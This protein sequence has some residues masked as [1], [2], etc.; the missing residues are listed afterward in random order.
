M[1]T[2]LASLLLTGLLAAPSH[3]QLVVGGPGVDPADFEVTVF[4]T[5][6]NFPVGMAELS[7]GSVLATVVTGTSYFGSTTGDLVRL[8]DTDDDGVA[9]VQTTAFSALPDG[10][11]TSVRIAGDLAFV[12]AAGGA[13]F[14]LRLGATPSDTLT[15]EG[16]LTFSYPIS[17][18]HPHSALA[19]RELPS[20]DLEL[21]FQIGS[22]TNFAATTAQATLTSDVGLSGSLDGDALYRATF[23]DDGSTVTGL[24]VIQLA[25]GLRNAAGIAFHATTGDLYFQD[26]G[27][28]GLINGAEPLSAD[29][30]NVIAA[31]DLGGAIEDFGFPTSYVEYRTGTVV[32]G[33]G[34]AP[35]VA[36]QPIPDPM[37][38]AE[39]EG[40]NDISFAPPGFPAVLRD[41][42]F[43][44]FHGQFPTAGVI[45][46]ENP[47]VFTDPV[48]GSYFHFVTNDLP[49]I[50]HLDGLL[51][52]SDALYL[53]DISPL[54][55]FG[56]ANANTGVIYRVRALPPAVDTVGP[57]ARTWLWI[58]LLVLGSVVTV[59][60]ARA[61]FAYL[62]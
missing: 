53:A 2:A 46:E 23:S 55:A 54:G 11:L 27:I 6:L 5:G 62:G 58:G 19:A 49:G 35:L 41:G 51:A 28:D 37:T 31:A 61:G 38:G 17:W 21:V 50:G 30:L 25:S 15:L 13:I 22:A 48:A 12:A 7:D 42:L 18:I 52:T 4:A 20:G 3:A 1:R 59:R 57:T 60:R 45:N 39:A 33:T 24:S 8:V 10:T 32:G 56:A 36:Y 9:D 14:V 40:P 47:V 44:G 16:T 26:N 43:L 29:E 34:V